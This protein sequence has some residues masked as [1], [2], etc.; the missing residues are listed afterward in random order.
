METLFVRG[1]GSRMQLLLPSKNG[2]SQRSHREVSACGLFPICVKS[3]NCWSS[4]RIPPHKQTNQISPGYLIDNLGRRSERR[5]NTPGPRKI[6][7]RARR[8]SRNGGIGARSRRGIHEGP[9]LR[10]A[11]HSTAQRPSVLPAKLRHSSPRR[12]PRD[13]GSS[14]MI[15]AVSQRSSAASPDCR[16]A[17][18]FCGRV[19]VVRLR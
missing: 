2:S 5:R 18:D 12:A 16:G 4:R 7:D 3:H 6:P 15:R 1:S 10:H 14:G 13:P 19:D 8:I 17:R 11:L 9:H